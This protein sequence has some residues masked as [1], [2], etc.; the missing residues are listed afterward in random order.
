MANFVQ[1]F[2]EHPV[3]VYSGGLVALTDR[4]CPEVGHCLAYIT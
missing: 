2:L 3:V 1:F 4:F